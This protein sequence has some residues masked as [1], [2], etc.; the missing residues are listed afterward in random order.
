[1]K[2]RRCILAG[3]LGAFAAVSAPSVA[4]ELTVT[5]ELTGAYD[6]ATF[7]A[8]PLP[9][10]TQ[11]VGAEYI[12]EVAISYQISGVGAEEGFGGMAMN[13]LTYGLTPTGHP[14]AVAYRDKH[15]YVGDQSARVQ[16]MPI[17]PPNGTWVMLWLLNEDAGADPK[18]MLNIA[19]CISG[20]GWRGNWQGADDPRL[21]LGKAE[22]QYVG[23]AYVAWNGQSVAALAVQVPR[24]GTVDVEG[25]ASL[26][27]EGTAIGS[28]LY[29]GLSGPG[30][31]GD[32]DTDDDV[33][34]DDLF[35]VRNN[36]GLPGDWEDG[37]FDGDGQVNL[38]D[39]LEIRNQM[40][41]AIP[42]G[43][44]V[45]PMPPPDAIRYG[46]DVNGDGDIDLDELFAVRNNFG[47]V[48]GA[49]SWTG[50]AYLDGTVYLSDLLAV[51]NNI[52]LT[53]LGAPESVP[54]PLSALLLVLAAPVLFSRR[55]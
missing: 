18:D 2:T 22:P 26:D 8:V 1:M 55:K 9:D 5:C 10:I 15:P 28:T 12:Y 33:D 19:V 51:R 14:Q 54:E 31:P 41:F 25:E 29:F 38:P 50:D 4:A 36:F 35:T 39:L 44:P 20:G 43:P 47:T 17:P 42:A 34:L 30:V 53:G 11:P 6:T 37:D 45:P 24:F 32:A 52:D 27:R 49:T 13:L 7:E 16:V 40:G 21:A 48:S 46:P 3:V 23:S